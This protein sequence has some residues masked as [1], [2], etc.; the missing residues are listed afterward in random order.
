MKR[1]F[2]GALLAVALVAAAMIAVAPAGSAPTR[3]ID[4]A[5][6]SDGHTCTVT[7]TSHQEISNYTV[8]GVKTE[9]PGTTTLVLTGLTE[10]TVI[11]VKAGTLTA[12]YTVQGP[13]AAPHDHDGDGHHDAPHH[14]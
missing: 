12:S 2:T 8:N 3:S 11:T 4:F 13:C 5:E 7:V 9:G 10:G 14:H 6:T 1:Y